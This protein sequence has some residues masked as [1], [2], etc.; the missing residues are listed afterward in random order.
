MCGASLIAQTIKNLPA[1]Q[2]TWF[3]LWIGKTLWRREWRPTPGMTEL[4][5]YTPETNT[6]YINYTSK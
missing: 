3:D 4:M 5:C 2:E 1:M 6:L